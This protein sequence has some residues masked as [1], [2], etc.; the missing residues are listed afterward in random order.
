MNEPQTSA[1]ARDWSPPDMTLLRQRS[2]LVAAIAG[3]ASIAGLFFDRAQFFQSYLVSWLFWLGITMGCFALMTLHHLTRGA[4]GLMVRRI[5]EAAT[6]NLPLMT[7]LFIPILLGLGDL[8]LWAR[9]EALSDELIQQKASYLNPTAFAIRSFFYLAVWTLF[10][11]ILNRLSLEQDK[12]GEPDLF[13]KMQLVSAAALVLFCLLSTFA[14]IDWL[15]S[16]DPHWYSSIFGVYFIIGEALAG[17]AFVIVMARYLSKREPL[18][19]VLQPRHIH[20][21]GN[22]LLAFVMLWAYIAVSQLIII[23]SGDLPEEVVWYLERIQGGW[24]GVSIALGV[25]HF[26]LPF[27][28]LLSRGFK[29]NIGALIQ[30]AVFLLIMRWVDLY[31]LAAPTFHHHLALHWLDLTTL[32]AIGGIWFS[33]FLGQLGNRSLLPVNDPYL[34]EA[35]RRHD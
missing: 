21:Y 32:L 9:P 4:W 29:R 33:L 15:M 25:F 31:W 24:L 18:R 16:L 6:R 20:D 35:I 14:S 1:P 28:I 34:D 2:W 30:V 3:V 8:Y 11:W 23:W 5:L 22:L 10:A 17:I 19:G 27:L 12:T 13:R 7:L 26:F